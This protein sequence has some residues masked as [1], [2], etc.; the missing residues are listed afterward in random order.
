M[1]VKKE[2]R[3]TKVHNLMLSLGSKT[4]GTKEHTDLLR[5]LHEHRSKMN[6]VKNSLPPEVYDIL[7]KQWGDFIE[8]CSQSGEH[9]E[10]LD[11]YFDQYL[12]TFMK[13]PH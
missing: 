11:K 9:I 8:T 12:A 10:D 6:E 7:T 3:R 4:E 1:S 5:E 2:E 13:Y